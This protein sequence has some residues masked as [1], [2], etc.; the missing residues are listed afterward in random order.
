MN[1][2]GV[3]K[4]EKAAM[5]YYKE[6]A[7]AGNAEGQYLYGSH[8]LS[9]SQRSLIKQANEYIN[10][11][12][13][14]GHAAAMY[15]LGLLHLDGNHLFYSCE[16]A[17]GMMKS[18]AERGLW[19]DK[20]KLAHLALTRGN[21]R[22]SFLLYLESAYLGL[23]NSAI[24]SALLADKY[25]V[26]GPEELDYSGIEDLIAN[27]EIFRIIKEQENKLNVI[28]NTNIFDF[29]Y[30][31]ILQIF[32]DKDVIKKTLRNPPTQ[33]ILAKQAYSIAKLEND[34]FSFLRLG[35]FYFYGIAVKQDYEKAYKSY[36]EVLKLPLEEIYQ[37]QA[38]FNMAYMHQYGLGISQDLNKSWEFYN[39]TYQLNKYALFS[40]KIS[41]F[42]LGFQGV[43][44][45]IGLF[46]LETWKPKITD[47]YAG[48]I[49]IGVIIW[50]GIEILR[51][52]QR[53]LIESLNMK[54]D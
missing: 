1:G 21:K 15:A 20:M 49:G 28:K 44:G 23:A 45:E 27:D 40:V 51:M 17:V 33:K 16:I 46:M 43:E 39:K 29:L 2:W 9:S 37:A 48:I 50:L 42:L 41:Q 5:N 30:E 34:P 13:H 11:A 53:N 47:I 38:Y 36:A 18:A 26:F 54:L 12:A 6:A 19:A 24:N 31:D 22:I 10:L 3:E 32:H 25:E 14:Q 35:D 7:D 52:R 4:N 8:L